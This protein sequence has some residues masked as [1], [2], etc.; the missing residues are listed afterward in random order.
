MKMCSLFQLSPYELVREGNIARNRVM[1]KELDLQFGAAAYFQG[2]EFSRNKMPQKTITPGPRPTSSTGI[3]GKHGRDSPPKG[4]SSTSLEIPSGF[5]WL[6]FAMKELLADLNDEDFKRV[7]TAW[8]ELEI[9]YGADAEPIALDGT[10]RPEDLK[11][12]KKHGRFTRGCKFRPKNIDSSEK[13]ANVF[14]AWW[15]SM[16]PAWRT[17]ENS[18]ELLQT[19]TGSWDVLRRPGVNGLYSVFISL[20]WWALQERWEVKNDCA[21]LSVR[22]KSALKDVEFALIGLL[23]EEKAE[24]NEDDEMGEDEQGEEDKEGRPVKRIRNV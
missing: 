23:D 20:V 13:F 14:W 7:V 8:A 11:A 22:W 3:L 21:T 12:W 6:S 9:L 10:G 2:P 16:N 4:T 5:S 1:L 18:S 15:K 19:N 24:E 17:V